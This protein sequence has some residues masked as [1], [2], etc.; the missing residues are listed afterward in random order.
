MWRQS[1]FI[2]M[3]LLDNG[4]TAICCCIIGLLLVLSGDDGGDVVDD[5]ESSIRWWELVVADVGVETPSSE[6]VVVT[7]AKVV[8]KDGRIIA[9]FYSIFYFIFNMMSCVCLYWNC[10]CVRECN[11]WYLTVVGLLRKQDFPHLLHSTVQQPW[12]LLKSRS[13][14][15]DIVLVKRFFKIWKKVTLCKC[16][17]VKEFIFFCRHHHFYSSQPSRDWFFTTKSMPQDTIFTR[18]NRM[19]NPC[20]IGILFRTVLLPKQASHDIIWRV[21]E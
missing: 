10:Y 2:S 4:V 13:E 16:R 21:N 15:W 8:K 1:S 3:L 18:L 20:I 11:D 6:G 5:D 12:R 7:L 9:Y 19:H 14:R 17:V